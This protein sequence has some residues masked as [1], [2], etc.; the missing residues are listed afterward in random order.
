MPNCWFI[1]G[2]VGLHKRGDLNHWMHLAT[3]IRAAITVLKDQP[4][5]GQGLVPCGIRRIPV[6][7]FAVVREARLW[8]HRETAG[9]LIQIGPFAVPPYRLDVGSIV[10]EADN[11]P[12]WAESHDAI[13]LW[14]SR[15]GRCA[16]GRTLSGPR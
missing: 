7:C 2:W 3:I 14:A 5:E 8:R 10:Q 11:V 15:S 13:G 4:L 9:G 1:L 12:I 6:G 16:V